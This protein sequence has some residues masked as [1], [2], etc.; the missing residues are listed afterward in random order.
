[1]FNGDLKA[2]FRLQHPD[3]NE[4]E[5]EKL[6]NPIRKSKSIYSSTMIALGRGMKQE[7]K[8]YLK[9]N[10]IGEIL[11]N[12]KFSK[13]TLDNFIDNFMPLL[14]IDKK[15]FSQDHIYQKPISLL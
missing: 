9:E 4:G 5:I 2:I 15:E 6:V 3:A 10:K 8:Y 14:E 11:L 1:M 7:M 12:L 13:A